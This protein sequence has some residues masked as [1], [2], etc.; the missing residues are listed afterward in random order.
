M[1][2]F[3]PNTNIQSTGAPKKEAAQERT[4]FTKEQ[5][6][7]SIMKALNNAGA[8]QTQKTNFTAQANSIFNQYDKSPQDSKWTETEANTGG[9]NA[10]AAFYNMVNN[11]MKGITNAASEDPQ[12]SPEAAKGVEEFNNLPPEQQSQ[13]MKQIILGDIFAQGNSVVDFDGDNITIRDKSG[14][15]TVIS[16]SQLGISSE[17]L[18]RLQPAIEDAISEGIANSAGDN[19]RIQNQV[20]NLNNVLS[21]YE[22]KGFYPVGTPVQNENGELIGTLKNDKGEEVK[23]NLNTGKEINDE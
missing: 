10:L 21:N 4:L 8:N 15:E 16:L 5:F 9:A 13:E 12:V 3:N 7:N 22:Q 2:D 1:V 6:T 11:A 20:N 19:L 17:A 14:T 23:I 18:E